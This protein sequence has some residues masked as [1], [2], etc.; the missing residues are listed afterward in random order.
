MAD[1]SR[2]QGD[3]CFCVNCGKY[4]PV[5]DFITKDARNDHDTP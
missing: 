3:T 5:G 1:E 2:R 4:F